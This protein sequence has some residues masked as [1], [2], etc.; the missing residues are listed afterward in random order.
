M[1]WKIEVGTCCLCKEFIPHVTTVGTKSLCRGVFG[2]ANVLSFGVV[3][4]LTFN[5]VNNVPRLAVKRFSQSSVG[6]HGL[7][8]PNS[9]KFLQ[10]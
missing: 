3:I 4:L 10:N 5:Q 7:I 1:A 8:I 2:L 9:A 6:L